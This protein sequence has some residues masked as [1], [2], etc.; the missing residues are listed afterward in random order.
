MKKVF[1]LV[2]VLCLVLVGIIIY[3]QQIQLKSKAAKTEVTEVIDS[4]EQD[5]QSS[6]KAETAEIKKINFDKIYSLH[7]PDEIVMA[8]NGEEI[9][10]QKYFHFFYDY[11]AQIENYIATYSYYGMDISWDESFDG[12]KTFK[13]LPGIYAEQD[14]KQYATI[15]GMAKQEGI[16]L[17]EEN[18]KAVGETI[19]NIIVESCGEEAT[20]EDFNQKLAES[21]MSRELYTD[22]ISNSYLY[23]QLFIEK[24]GEGGASL[25]DNEVIDY[26]K[27]E[28][29]IC[30]DHILFSTVDRD[31]GETPSEDELREKKETAERIIVELKG[32]E[33]RKERYEKFLE[34]RDEYSEDAGKVTYPDG[35]TFTEGKMVTEF[36]EAARALEEYEIS[37]I[38]ESTYGYH[39]IMKLPLSS[40]AIIE[41]SD[42]QTPITACAKC[43]NGKY[44]DALEKYMKNITV[45]YM[46]GF[47]IPVVTD[48]VEK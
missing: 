39:I 8:V 5:L 28:G 46:Q 37:E 44:G 2:T 29:Y 18:K 20:D 35:Y 3:Q 10:W 16:E 11:A 4:N 24:Y 34:Y 31:T 23:Q 22:L 14:L 17:N 6:E 48:Y 33:D 19:K 40:D 47:E 41:Y 25:S 1:A 9:T 26:L 38:V 15:E 42:N 36:D 13:E 30:A 32:I 12:E 21:Y 43:A 7:N 45:E 27:K